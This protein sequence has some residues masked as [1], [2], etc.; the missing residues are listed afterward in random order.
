M[1]FDVVIQ[2]YTP[3]IEKQYMLT[4]EAFIQILQEAH[5]KG[6]K[7]DDP[8]RILVNQKL[9]DYLLKKATEKHGISGGC[10]AGIAAL[11]IDPKLN[12]Y[13]CARL[14]V[15][16]GNLHNTSL[17]DIWLGDNIILKKLRER[18]LK[19]KCNKCRYKLI[20]GG[21]RADAYAVHGDIFAEDPLC[22]LNTTV[23]I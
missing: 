6:V 12:V 1:G 17:K 4:Q 19:G 15:N 11:T 18:R 3:T 7:I 22:P 20:C 2:F 5:L 10:T 14:R 16:I 9:R 23:N 21:C 8:R 13:P